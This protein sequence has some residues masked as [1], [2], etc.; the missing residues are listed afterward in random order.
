MVFALFQIVA[1]QHLLMECQTYQTEHSLVLQQQSR[2]NRT[3]SLM[4]MTVSSAVYMAQHGAAIHSV[5][6]VRPFHEIILTVLI[7]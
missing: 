6:V 1:T 2:V 4:V 7:F 5:F 3:T